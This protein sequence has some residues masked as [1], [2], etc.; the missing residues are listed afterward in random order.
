MPENYGVGA[1]LAIWSRYFLKDLLYIKIVDIKYLEECEMKYENNI[2]GEEA[3]LTVNDEINTEKNENTENTE[4]TENKENKENAENKVSLEKAPEKSGNENKDAP[5]E[6]AVGSDDI[7][8]DGADDIVGEAA[9]DIADESADDAESGEEKP[10]LQEPVPFSYYNDGISVFGFSRVGASHIN[11]EVPCQD[12]SG[13]RS[14]KGKLV[15]TAVA[16]GVGSCKYSEY[17][18]Q[19]AVD[20]CLDYLEG[21]LSSVV[22]EEFVL[23]GALA[24]K[25]LR[26]AMRFAY[27][28][29]E[30]KS[31]EMGMTSYDLQSTLT[32]VIYDGENLYF[33]HAGDDGIVAINK[34]GDYWL[35]SSR[36]K[37]EEASSVYPL[38]SLT[39]WQFGMAKDV[40]AYILATDGVLDAF[41]RGEAEN[42]RIYFPF[43]RSAV[44][45]SVDGEKGARELCEA[46]VEFTDSDEYRAGVTDD[47][48]M[49]CVANGK[50]IE[51][52]T[53]PVFD[54][55]AWKRDSEMYA[56]MRREAL[57]PSEKSENKANGDNKDNKESKEN[58]EYKCY[59]NIKTPANDTK[60]A[61]HD[62]DEPK[63]DSLTLKTVEKDS[64]LRPVKRNVGTL[65]PKGNTGALKGEVRVKRIR[66]IEVK[67]PEVKITVVTLGT[68]REDRA[69]DK[70][71]ACNGNTAP[72]EAHSPRRE[73]KNDIGTSGLLKDFVQRL[74]VI[75]GRIMTYSKE[76]VITNEGIDPADNKKNI[77]VDGNNKANSKDNSKDNTNNKG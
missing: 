18:A 7:L 40:V 24:G 45:A 20:S 28:S 10:K 52:A 17:G 76:E 77:G 12:R 69:P 53:P 8:D 11:K 25:L 54:K 70:S 38:Q 50:A 21:Q 3:A 34:N 16:D 48:T 49:V 26:D 71:E 22:D 44:Y 19:T 62:D 9:D 65:T 5:L 39:T 41:V 63:K 74:K 66:R 33:G 67:V 47:I 59:N 23:T 75:G 58:K 13:M 51:K 14:I 72:T 56:K 46:W 27:D 35:V 37:A 73:E 15:I 42:N 30:N 68:Q 2:F 36:H 43:M 29:V 64:D 55:E 57:Y 32:V 4:N 6:E 1:T 31:T 61:A 60:A